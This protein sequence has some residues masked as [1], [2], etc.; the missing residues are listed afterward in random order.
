MKCVECGAEVASGAKF[1]SECG[2]KIIRKI[3]CSECGTELKPDQKFCS[4]CGTPNPSLATPQS[5]S[6]AKS[7]QSVAIE[8]FEKGLI[9][10]GYSA[11]DSDTG[12]VAELFAPIK[13]HENYFYLHENADVVFR[14]D[15]GDA[16]IWDDFDP[17]DGEAFSQ[18]VFSPLDWADSLEE[19][20]EDVLKHFMSALNE[21][22]D[23]DDDIPTPEDNKI[24]L[25]LW[26][27]GKIVYEHEIEFVRESSDDNDDDDDD[28]IFAN[29]FND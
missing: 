7:K 18:V 2:A 8:D 22:V 15:F 3:F 24:R 9:Y 13:Y 4:E 25:I 1:C 19:V 28:D 17:E 29:L 27:D 26:L 23:E 11:Q 14:K 10:V 20:A 5:K 12:I 21:A 16:S 6:K